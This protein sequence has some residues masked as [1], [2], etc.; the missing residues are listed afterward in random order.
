M[1]LIP[2][3]ALALVAA[4]SG[5]STYQRIDQ[6][7]DR[8]KSSFDDAAGQAAALRQAG[9]GYIKRADT[10]WVATRPLPRPVSSAKIPAGKDCNLRFIADS[11]MPLQDF[12]QAITQDCHIPVTV[13]P[14]AW[15][16]LMGGASDGGGRLPAASP[17][18]GPFPPGG[19]PTI[20][21]QPAPAQSRPG[22]A[23]YRN[24]A[25]VQPVK[26]MNR[27]L[28]GLLDVVT[29]Q[30][31]ISW[32]YRDNGL[33]LHYLDTKTF[34]LVQIGSDT[35][36]QSSVV[37]GSSLT[38]TNSGGGGGTGSGGSNSSNTTGESNQQTKVT[39]KS[40]V[41]ADLKR[42][43]E[44]AM[45]EQGRLAMSMST[46]SVTV[47]DTPDALARVS[48]L[49]DHVNEQMG[50]Q[51]M[52]YVTVAMVTLDDAD[53][54]GINWN[55]VFNSLS[56]D[57]GISLANSFTPLENAATAG[58][59]VLDTATG[60][61]GQFKGTTA[62]LSAL[63]K[64]G[65]VSIYKQRT[66]TTANLQPAPIQMTS[67]EQ[68]ICGRTNSTTAQVGVTEGIQLCP[69]VT[70]FSMDILPYI[71]DPSQLSIQFGMNMAPPPVISTLPGDPEKPVQKAKVARQVFQQRV[72]L[73]SNQTV[74][75][76]DFQESSE[77]ATKQGIGDLSAWAMF[78]GGTRAGA[79]KVVVIM[80]TPV[81]EADT[82]L[83]FAS[84]T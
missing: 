1:K 11:E 81:I 33:V 36:F 46:G 39:I 64:Q 71:M 29:A 4:L 32:S 50:R 17:A 49:I 7:P 21:A 62:V 37:S 14:D 43:I 34:Q 23:S 27:P 69:V 38:N 24:V 30:L 3:S 74:L 20:G 70:G 82:P 73:K 56:G 44:T 83:P 65:S 28:S 5:C 45:S 19:I 51:V 6:A 66:V 10:P 79:R 68:Y 35:D 72:R 57:Y 8:A 41:T 13:T 31:G 53:S 76:S 67:E 75:L 40:S 78:G 58:F 22:L 18:A 61:A 48:R 9:Q 25:V 54:L 26:W 12:V 77:D 16:A 80:I 15:A 84:R 52:L 59:G 63:A 2:F 42:S 47:T 55:A 60:R